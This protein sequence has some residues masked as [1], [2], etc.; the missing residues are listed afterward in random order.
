LQPL[1]DDLVQAKGLT[2]AV[3]AIS[4]CSR[5]I[6]PLQDQAHPN[7]EYWG[8][9]DPNRPVQHKVSKVEMMAHAKSAPRDLGYTAF[10]IWY[11]FDFDMH[12]SKV[13]ESLL[14]LS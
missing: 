4:F 6:Q 12:Q 7:F 3:V 2:D 8:Q 11:V 5:L 13:F 14:L 9:S 1:L 10:P